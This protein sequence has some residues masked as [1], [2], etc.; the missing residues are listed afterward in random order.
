MAGA[1]PIETERK[2]LLRS[3]GWRAGVT[4]SATIEQAY[5]AMADRATV[6]VRRYGDKGFVTVKGRRSGVSRVE[7]ETE[8]TLDFARA[9]L[10]SDLLELPPLVKTRHLVPVDGLLFEI[11]EFAGRNAGLVIAEVCR[12][13]RRDQLVRVNTDSA[14]GP[15]GQPAR[16][17][18]AAR[19]LCLV[20]G[21]NDSLAGFLRG[22][23]R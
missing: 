8:V 21:D 14:F 12:P 16:R 13:G 17:P 23:S 20:S 11:D 15:P 7:L 3:N 6:R 1:S 4:A 2:F 19:Y 18:C 22:D 9:L 5:V 10:R